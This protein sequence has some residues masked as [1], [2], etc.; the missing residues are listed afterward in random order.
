MFSFFQEQGE[1]P[2]IEASASAVLQNPVPGLANQPFLRP[3]ADTGLVEHGNKKQ[4]YDNPY[5]EPQYGFPSEDDPDAEEQVESY[6]P[7]F[8]Q[9][10]NGNKCVKLVHHLNECIIII[11]M[12]ALTDHAMTSFQTQHVRVFS[13]FMVLNLWWCYVMWCEC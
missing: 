11:Q 4:E 2:E 6:T 1:V 8:N 12:G 5:F 13:S 9:N 7:R 3:A 10:L